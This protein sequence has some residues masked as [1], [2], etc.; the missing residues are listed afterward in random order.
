MRYEIIGKTMP[1]LEVTFDVPGESVYTQ[2]GGMTWMSDGVHMDSNMKGG[3]G[4]ILR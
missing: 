1:A 3:F 4:K 2:S